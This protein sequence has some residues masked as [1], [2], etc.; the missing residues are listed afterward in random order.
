MTADVS[1]HIISWGMT[2]GKLW[3]GDL[4]SERAG[5]MSM[6]KEGNNDNEGSKGEASS[7]GNGASDDQ[8]WNMEME[9][10]WT[11]SGKVL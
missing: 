2:T 8:G 1:S 6:A 3:L 7:E 5:T 9:P 10:S 11:A 4:Q